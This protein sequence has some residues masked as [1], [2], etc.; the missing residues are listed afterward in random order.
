[1]TDPLS[2]DT[3]GFQAVKTCQ[4]ANHEGT[5]SLLFI[6]IPFPKKVCLLTSTNILEQQQKSD[7]ILQQRKA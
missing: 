6:N 7:F 2:E 4:Q 5:L 3:T 1:M